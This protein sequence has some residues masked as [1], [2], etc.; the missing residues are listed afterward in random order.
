MKDLIS[1]YKNDIKSENSW[2][3]CRSVPHDGFGSVSLHIVILWDCLKIY[4]IMWE[5]EFSGVHCAGFL[6]ESYL[7]DSFLSELLIKQL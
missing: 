3:L 7:H 5:A 2:R 1:P 4:N 6:Y